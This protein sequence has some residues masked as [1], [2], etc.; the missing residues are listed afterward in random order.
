MIHNT[1]CLA[2]PRRRRD[3][4]GRPAP[5]QL[6]RPGVVEGEL[7]GDKIRFVAA[8]EV[9]AGGVV[10]S[11]AAARVCS[12]GLLARSAPPRQPPPHPPLPPPHPIQPSTLPLTQERTPA[13]LPPS[14]QYFSLAA[15]EH[16]IYGWGGNGYKCIGIGPTHQQVGVG[17]G[18]CVWG[19]GRPRRPRTVA[20]VWRR[21]RATRTRW[22]WVGWVGHLGT[23]ATGAGGAAG[24]WHQACRQDWGREVMELGFL[25][26][27][28]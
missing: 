3:V 20:G 19:G 27:S 22:V 26:E 24:G 7:A 16:Y 28:F 17:V 21:R 15:S 25:P 11:A 9:R 23:P 10:R 13:A 18:G 2:L 8:G 4:A 5:A 12:A 1:C 6:T 14:L